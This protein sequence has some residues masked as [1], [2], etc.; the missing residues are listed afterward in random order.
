MIA[1]FANIAMAIGV[2][3]ICS[4]VVIG[5]VMVL[6]SIAALLGDKEDW[7]DYEDWSE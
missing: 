5:F 3:I 7:E 2:G 4:I 1:H 6:A